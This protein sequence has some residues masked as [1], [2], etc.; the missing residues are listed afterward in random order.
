MKIVFLTQ[1]Q[2]DIFSNNHPLHTMYQTSMYASLMEK[3]GYTTRYFG[4]VDDKN[5]LIGATLLLEKKLILNFKYAYAP[6]GF[7]INYDD[8][9]LIKEISIKFKDYLSKNNFIFLKI[10]PPVVNNKRDRNG[11]IVPSTYSNDLIP[12]LKSI[13]YSHFGE[14][15]FFGTLKP[16]WNAILKVTGSSKTLFNNFDKNIKNK[17]RKAESRGVEI[18]QGTKADLEVFYSFVAKK[19]YRNLKYYQDF[20]DSF[21]DKFEIYFAKL[22]TENYLKNIKAIYEEEINNNAKINDQIQLESINEGTIKERLINSKITSDRLLAI[23]KKELLTASK[24]FETNPNGL[25]IASCAIVI[26][27]F[28]INL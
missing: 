11:N 21:K 19:H 23:Y 17:I 7:L 13:G 8:K 20:Q 14:N 12:Y 10:D 1:Q 6:R 18:I 28:S 4:F 27:K 2:F 5:N 24:L 15:K 16:R 3:T 22:N 25:I 9:D 26:E